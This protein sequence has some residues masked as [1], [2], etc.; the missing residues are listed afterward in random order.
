V[1][2]HVS[3]VFCQVINLRVYCLI[4]IPIIIAQS[5]TE[6]EYVATNSAAK[7]IVWFR[8]IEKELGND[9][10]PTIIMETISQ[11]LN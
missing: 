10:S 9:L 2:Y 1:K 11:Q 8:I 3:V 6:A 7:E 5:S 4:S